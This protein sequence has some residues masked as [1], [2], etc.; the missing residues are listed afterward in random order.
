VLLNLKQI[1]RGVAN[2]ALR[3]HPERAPRESAALWYEQMLR[4]LAR[5]GW[6]K[7]PAQTPHDFVAAIR[8][9]ELQRK[10]ATFTRAYES[11]RFGQSTKDALALPEL[12]EE[13]TTVDR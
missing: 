11:A 4:R 13:I 12:I 5:R 7:S 2:R 6:K 9:P 3:A 1:I 8:E 10:V